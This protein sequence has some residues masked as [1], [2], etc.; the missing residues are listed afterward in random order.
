MICKKCDTDYKL[1]IQN[2]QHRNEMERLTEEFIR[3]RRDMAYFQFTMSGDRKYMDKYEFE[4]KN[5]G[6]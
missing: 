6:F 5:G 1:H 3:L 4:R 2:L